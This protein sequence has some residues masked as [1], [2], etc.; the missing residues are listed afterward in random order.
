MQ[1]IQFG[2]VGAVQYVF[3]EIAALV[4]GGAEDG[5]EVGHGWGED[6]RGLEIGIGGVF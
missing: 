4:A 3:D 5:E 1:V 2:E 6:F